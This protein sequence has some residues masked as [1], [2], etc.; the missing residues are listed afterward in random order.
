MFRLADLPQLTATDRLF[1]A[2]TGELGG[3]F[4]TPLVELLVRQ[5]APDRTRASAPDFLLA[6]ADEV[7]QL[8]ARGNEGG[9]G[10]VVHRV[11]HV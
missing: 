9:V 8:V 6:V 4:P 1:L 3:E 11:V 10:V 2:V 5:F 7:D